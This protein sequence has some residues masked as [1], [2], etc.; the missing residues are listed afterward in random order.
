[1]GQKAEYLLNDRPPSVNSLNDCFF[2]QQ[3]RRST[4]LACGK[5]LQI[6]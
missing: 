6:M 3:L 1:M 4:T 5:K 2:I